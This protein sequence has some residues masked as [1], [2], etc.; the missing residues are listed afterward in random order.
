M[1]HLSVEKAL[2]ALFLER[3]K[4]DPPKSHNL[5]HFLTGRTSIL[6]SPDCSCP[7]SS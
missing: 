2:K 3:T 5:L 7:S 6:T 1:C 4:N